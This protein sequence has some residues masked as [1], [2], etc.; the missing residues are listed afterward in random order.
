[1]YKDVLSL[2]EREYEQLFEE[3]IDFQTIS[4]AEICLDEAI[5]EE[6][7][8]GTKEY[9]IDVIW[10]ELQTSSLLLEAII[11]LET[12]SKLLKSL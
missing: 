8:D 1:M 9:R 2:S 3:F 5:I 11:D 4:E 6:H 7:E 10:Y 12:Y